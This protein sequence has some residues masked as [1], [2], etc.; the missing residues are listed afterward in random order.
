MHSAIHTKILNL[1][2]P[3]VLTDINHRVQHICKQPYRF[4]PVQLNALQL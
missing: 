3:A 4:P 1:T 2:L